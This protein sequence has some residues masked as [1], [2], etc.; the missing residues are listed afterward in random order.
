MNDPTSSPAF[1]FVTCQ[2]GAEAPLK[3]QVASRWPEHRFAYSRP[4]FVTF[5]L[6]PAAPLA[7]DFDLE[8]P[9]A[10]AYGFSLGE[11]AAETLEARASAVWRLAAGRDFARLHVWPRDER[12]AGDHGYQP[13]HTPASREAEAALR[14]AAPSPVSEVS[15]PRA[16]ERVLD[17]VLM[18]E[19]QWWAGFHQ[20]GAGHLPWPGGLSSLELPAHAV[21]RAYLKAAEALEW[22]G[23]PVSSGD[24][25]A[26][27]GASPGGASQALL[28][29]GL[30]VL[31]I[32]PAEIHPAVLAH[33][34]FTHLRKRSHE[35]RRRDFRKVRWLLADMNVAP[36]Y[37]LDAVEDI[38][39]HPETNI[40][41]VLLTLKLPEW[42]LLEDAPAWVER[43]RG[44]GYG[45]VALRQLGHHRQEL[46]LAGQR[47]GRRR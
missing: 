36:Q 15:A 11:V 14:A 35:V 26:E 4:G 25:C 13:G 5:K 18:R 6:P 39:R 2:A 1:L 45:Q 22:S 7:E 46:A 17:V 32:D 42:K 24:T 20:H 34:K 33:P 8:S 38:V 41:G 40:R 21:S 31:G 29:R 23:L 10:R 19:D 27:L 9:L 28:D 43:V 44:W 30:E 37:T 47:G 3:Q 16:G 12:P